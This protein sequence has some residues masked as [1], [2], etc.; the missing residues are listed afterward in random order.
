[1]TKTAILFLAE[2]TEEMEFSIT[3]DILVRGGIQARSVY[4]PAEGAPASPPNGMVT[5][6]R[7]VKLGVDTT[8]ADL[9]KQGLN[10]VDALI[11]PGGVGGA[12]TISKNPGVLRL[13][14][15]AYDQGK[16]IGM[17]CAGSLAALEA[18]IGLN[19]AITSHPSVKDK[20]SASFQYQES[21]VVVAGP[22]VTSRGPG[23]TFAFA[24]T[25][26]EKLVGAQVRQEITPPM[27]LSQEHL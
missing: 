24:L 6:S 14:K 18:K 16:I 8:L 27:M 15:E 2:G 7:G 11:V 17:I 13:L 1:M 5:A 19:D 4:V 9:E 22:L 20:L 23:T 21:N 25:L 3:Y 26:V 10:E 12:N